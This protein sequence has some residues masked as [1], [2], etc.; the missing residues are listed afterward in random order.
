VNLN[1]SNPDAA[2]GNE[3]K[4]AALDKTSFASRYEV[5][6]RT[7]DNWIAKGL[8]ILK[9]S[10]RQVRIPIPDADVWVREK[11]FQQRRAA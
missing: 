1:A 2:T 6:R 3:N 7:C 4:M 5:S 9:L 10:Q 11:F 8:P